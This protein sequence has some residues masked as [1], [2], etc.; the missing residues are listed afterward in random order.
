MSPTPRLLVLELRTLQTRNVFHD[1]F[2]VGPA[3]ADKSGGKKEIL[4]V[5]FYMGNCVLF[6]FG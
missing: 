3:A 1:L 2:I 4:K 5:S 6:S